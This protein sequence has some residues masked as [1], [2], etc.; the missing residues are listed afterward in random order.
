MQNK[1][2]VKST[3]RDMKI[4]FEYDY[5]TSKMCT[6]FGVVKDINISNQYKSKIK[7]YRK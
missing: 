6:A 1:I 3:F 5:Y 4:H 7:I 2:G